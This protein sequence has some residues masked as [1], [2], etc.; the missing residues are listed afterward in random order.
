MRAG[1]RDPPEPQLVVHS[2]HQEETRTAPVAGAPQEPRPPINA[3]VL[4][5]KKEK[6]A[7]WVA[8]T[9]PVGT[10]TGKKKYSDSGNT[11]GHL[12]LE[13]GNPAA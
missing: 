2:G 3:S 11:L 6:L 4:T 13:L 7:R 9:A 5:E 12:K 8:G 1:E 10:R